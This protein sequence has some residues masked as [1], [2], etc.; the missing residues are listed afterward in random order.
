MRSDQIFIILAMGTAGQRCTT[1]RRLFVHDSLYDAFFFP[2]NTDQAKPNPETTD[3]FDSGLRYRSSK[4]QAQVGA[5]YTRFN[6][7]LASAYD[8]ELDTTVFRNLGRVNKW[9][10]DGSVAYAPMRQL[11][12]YAFGSWN[13]SKIKENLQIE[14]GASYDCNNADVSTPAARATAFRNCAFTAGNHEA[15]TPKYT[16]G[17]SA[18]VNLGDF[19]FGVTGKR[20][21]PRFIY[22]TNRPVLSGDVDVESGIRQLYSAKAAAYWLVN[23]DLRYN[24]RSW[25]P[26]MDKTYLQFNVYNLFDETY[27]GGFGGGLNQ[28]V[29]SSGFY[30]SAPFVQ[31][32][33]PRTISG[34]LNIGF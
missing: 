17:G 11:T 33:A 4:L 28:S 9:G 26:G 13:Q 8:P 30:G 1:L 22:D 2:A 6:D 25:G 18:L 23:L 32:G 21:G 19:D 16:F 12:L 7:R 14:G 34:T 3:T 5:W 29:S 20:T 24:L 15:G 10:I 27:V 31:I